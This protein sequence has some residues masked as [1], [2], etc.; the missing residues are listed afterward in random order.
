MVTT[1]DPRRVVF[2]FAHVL[3]GRHARLVVEASENYTTPFL[4]RNSGHSDNCVNDFVVGCETDT[5]VT[6][7][8]RKRSTLV[9]VQVLHNTKI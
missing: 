4:M 6:V 8:Q 1:F 5:V 3:F 7:A 2:T 9:V